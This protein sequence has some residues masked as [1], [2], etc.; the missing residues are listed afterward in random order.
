MLSLWIE[1]SPRTDA[2]HKAGGPTHKH[3]KDLRAETCATYNPSFVLHIAAHSS[4]H[5]YRLKLCC[6]PP[7]HIHKLEST[8]MSTVVI[9]GN[10]TGPQYVAFSTPPL[11]SPS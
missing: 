3:T 8:D 4:H 10:I 2:S 1:A 9:T 11:P 5:G 6:I 7:D